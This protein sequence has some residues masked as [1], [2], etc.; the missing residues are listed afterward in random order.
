[1][2]KTESHGSKRID[3]PILEDGLH[4]SSQKKRDLTETEKAEIL[5]SLFRTYI[6]WVKDL[7]DRLRVERT[8]LKKIFEEEMK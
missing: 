8:K 4:F 5:Q 6:R 2:E 1:M 3:L 7:S